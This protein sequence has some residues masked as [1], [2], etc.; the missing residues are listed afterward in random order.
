M[1][2]GILLKAYSVLTKNIGSVFSKI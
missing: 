2:T 1:L